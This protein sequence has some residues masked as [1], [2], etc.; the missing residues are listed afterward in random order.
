MQF[1][2]RE[3][4]T[5]TEELQ[6]VTTKYE[7]PAKDGCNG[8]AVGSLEDNS[9]KGEM[10]VSSVETICSYSSGGSRVDEVAETGQA[11]EVSETSETSEAKEAQGKK[12]VGGTSKTSQT[13]VTHKTSQTD[14]T[15]KTSQTDVTHRTNINNRADVAARPRERGRSPTPGHSSYTRQT[16]LSCALGRISSNYVM[17]ASNNTSRVAEWGSRMS[18]STSVNLCKVTKLINLREDLPSSAMYIGNGTDGGR[19]VEVQE[20]EEMPQKS[21]THVRSCSMD[22]HHIGVTQTERSCE[23]GLEHDGDMKRGPSGKEDND[24]TCNSCTESSELQL[25]KDQSYDLCSSNKRVFIQGIQKKNYHMNG[26]NTF[27]YLNEVLEKTYKETVELDG[28]EYIFLYDICVQD[29]DASSQLDKRGEFIQNSSWGA[30]ASVHTTIPL[31]EENEVLTL[32]VY[33]KYINIFHSFSNKM[34]KIRRLIY[35]IEADVSAGYA[36]TGSLASTAGAA[37][38]VGSDNHPETHRRR[39]GQASHMGGTRGRMV[40][41]GLDETNLE[42]IQTLFAEEGGQMRSSPKMKLLDRINCLILTAMGRSGTEEGNSTAGEDTSNSSTANLVGD[43]TAKMASHLHA[44]SSPR[45]TTQLLTPLDVG[46]I[47]QHMKCSANRRVHESDI[48]DI[49]I[50]KR[51]YFYLNVRNGHWDEYYC[52]LFHLKNNNVLFKNDLLYT[53]YCRVYDRGVLH[54]VLNSPDLYS[55]YFIAF[56]KDPNFELNKLTNLD[57]CIII[58]K[59]YYPFVIELSR[60]KKA[61]VIIHTGQD[62]FLHVDQTEA[63]RVKSSLILFD[64]NSEPFYLIP[65]EWFPDDG[66]AV[67]SAG[68]R[69]NKGTANEPS[70][71]G[72]TPRRGRVKLQYG[73]LKEWNDCLY[74][75][76]EKAKQKNTNV[77]DK[78]GQSEKTHYVNRKFSQWIEAFKKERNIQEHA[79]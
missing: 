53:H 10:S 7:H 33:N 41:G 68:G 56:F 48:Y 50:M 57:L 65:F 42:S 58:R 73:L 28:S 8:R 29:G 4:H 66:V 37:S 74:S 51:G 52:V 78:R 77:C 13:D 79:V 59:N 40:V 22:S 36:C 27:T 64:I 67:R 14:V 21:V 31:E 11:R 16:S 38:K 6:D 15:H 2:Q 47:K 25:A 18:A 34:N 69:V 3:K 1:E 49:Q 63:E 72:S 23:S 39:D 55:N 60:S 61:S 71:Q 54:N 76:M 9:I 35:P 12:E 62:I 19:K 26:T 24:K 30:S 70:P 75:V 32:N 44:N 43:S 20:E 17:H 46:K 5:Q 45:K